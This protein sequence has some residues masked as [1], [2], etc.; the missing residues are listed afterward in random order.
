VSRT[1]LAFV[2]RRAALALAF[3]L[4]VGAAAFLI[5]RIAP[6]DIS[7]A[8]MAAGDDPAAIAAARDRLG[9][10]RPVIAHLGEWLSRAARLDL[11]LSERFR[12][13]VRDLVADRALRTAMLAS[14][15]LLLA[16]AIGLPLGL[17]T[18]ARPDG[19]IARMVTPVSIALVS[20]PPIVAALGLLLLGHQLPWFPDEPD[21]IVIPALALALP[22][23]AWLER[24]QS[25]ATTDMLGAPDLLAT[26]A[27]GVPARALLWRHV[28]RQSLRPVLGVYGIVIGG[29]FSGSLAVEWVT[30]WNGLGR[31]TYDALVS[32]DLFLIAG[33]ALAGAVLIAIGNLVADLLRAL[34]DPRVREAA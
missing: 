24:L 5:A 11:G 1:I 30:S 3:M 15:A 23:A 18:G 26:A 16:T 19:W 4:L 22:L 25:R 8:M 27:R 33:C 10:D 31:L 13:P 9:L 17:L 2:L 32:R 34:A 7:T 20:C 29:L 14:V 28:A 12:V 6:G 21:T